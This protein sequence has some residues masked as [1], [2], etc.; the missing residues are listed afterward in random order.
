M[1]NIELKY[2]CQIEILETLKQ[3]SS[4][5]FKMLSEYYAFSN[6]FTFS[7]YI[8]IYIYMFREFGIK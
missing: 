8:Y 1:I 5:P 6:P 4:D 2:Y 7:I 3:M